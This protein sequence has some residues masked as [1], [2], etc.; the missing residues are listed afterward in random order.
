MD[1]ALGVAALTVEEEGGEEACIRGQAVGHL[2]VVAGTLREHLRRYDAVGRTVEGDFLLVLPDVSRRGLVA[3]AERLRQELAEECDAAF[4][5]S[6]ALAHYDYVDLPAPEI[7]ASVVRRAST[8][9]AAGE[10]VGWV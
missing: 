4:R 3:V 2:R 8:A 1:L 9:M 7:V 6:F 5:C 10:A